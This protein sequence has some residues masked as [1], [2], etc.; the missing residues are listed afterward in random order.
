VMQINVRIP[1]GASSGEVPVLLRAG[2]FQSQTGVTV[3][4]E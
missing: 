2:Q 4:V 1:V 3:V